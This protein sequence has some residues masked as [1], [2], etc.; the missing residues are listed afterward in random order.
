MTYFLNCADEKI[1][2]ANDNK[3]EKAKECGAVDADEKVDD[4]LHARQCQD[5]SFTSSVHCS[6]GGICELLIG[7]Y[8]QVAWH[9][10]SGSGS[11]FGSL[12]SC[13]EIILCV[14]DRRLCLV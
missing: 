4:C 10:G 3:L 2:S 6:I 8:G 7:G 5:E 12:T 13:E 9:T 1:Q 11:L 14:G